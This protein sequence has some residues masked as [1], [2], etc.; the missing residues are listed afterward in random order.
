V[1]NNAVVKVL[2]TEIVI[3]SSSPDLEDIFLNNQERH[4]KC[5]SFKVKYEDVVLADDIIIE[6]V[7]GGSKG[8]LVGDLKTFRPAITPASLVDRRWKSLKLAGTEMTA[9][10]T[11]V[12][13]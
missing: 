10:E 8:R 4:T 9:C 11:V 1:L 12:P 13:R 5:S 6:A 2:A 7:G 3:T